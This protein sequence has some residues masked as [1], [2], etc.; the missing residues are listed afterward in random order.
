MISTEVAPAAVQQVPGWAVW[1]LRV[2]ALFVAVFVFVQPVLAGLFVTGEVGM[3]GL[4]SVNANLI[5][6]LVIV[7]AVAAILLWR[8]GR[9][10]AWPIWISI[11]YLVLIEAQAGFGYARLVALHI[12]FGV[13]LFGLA[14]AM[15]IG[16]WSPRLRVCR[17]TP[18]QRRVNA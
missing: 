13:A 17:S 6:L 12:P 15:L 8:P 1:F 7:Q 10:P 11:A 14:V 18:R 2:S 9:G 16:T 4:H 5:A 3:L